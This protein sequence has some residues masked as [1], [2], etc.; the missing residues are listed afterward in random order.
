MRNRIPS[1]LLAIG[2]LIVA[3]TPRLLKGSDDLLIGTLMGAG[4][5]IEL[6]GVTM[7]IRRARGSRCR[8]AA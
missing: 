1:L 4:I 6:L 3:L 7:M 8:R 5:G 2:L